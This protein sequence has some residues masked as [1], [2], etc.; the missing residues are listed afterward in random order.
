MKMRRF[1]ISIF[2]NALQKISVAFWLHFAKKRS[3]ITK[4]SMQE[5]MQ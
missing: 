5:A 4:N 3:M 1:R 2:R